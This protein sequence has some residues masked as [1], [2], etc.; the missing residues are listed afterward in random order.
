MARKAWEFVGAAH[1]RES[2]VSRHWSFQEEKEVCDLIHPLEIWLQMCL[3]SRLQRAQS[4]GSRTR[5]LPER[6]V[7]CALVTVSSQG[8]MAKFRLRFRSC[9]D[10]CDEQVEEREESMTLWGFVL[11]RWEICDCLYL[12]GGVLILGLGGNQKFCFGYLRL[13]IYL[14]ESNPREDLRGIINIWRVNGWEFSKS[15]VRHHRLRKLH[16]SPNT[17]SL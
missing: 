7:V 6:Q 1:G 8:R 3:K 9:V 11:R 12:A 13:E 5:S 2:R 17:Q 4:R 14:R 15:D 10:G 16:K